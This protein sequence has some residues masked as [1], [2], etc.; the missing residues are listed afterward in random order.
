[1][2]ANGTDIKTVS[3]RLGHSNIAAIGNIY[4]HALRTADE[5]AAERL[6]DILR[7]NTG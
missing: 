4:A 5:P 2:I 3:K 1:M 6:T 7:K